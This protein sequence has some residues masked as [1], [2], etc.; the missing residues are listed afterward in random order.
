MEIRIKKLVGA[1][2]G[3]TGQN[4]CNT[5]SVFAIDGQKV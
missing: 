4:P 3:I 1:K 5:I 2:S